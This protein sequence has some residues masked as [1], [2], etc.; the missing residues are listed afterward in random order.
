[1]YGIPDLDGRGPH[2]SY[3]EDRC[4]PTGE[5]NWT[6]SGH[7]RK[8]GSSRHQLYDVR[9]SL[10]NSP[11][12]RRSP[13]SF[14]LSPHA[15]A[16]LHV[17]N[18]FNDDSKLWEIWNLCDP[19][20]LVSDLCFCSC[21]SALCPA[22]AVLRT[23]IC[24]LFGICTVQASLYLIRFLKD[25]LV[26][27]IL[28]STDTI[29]EVNIIHFMHTRLHRLCCYGTPTLPKLVFNRRL[30]S[31]SFQGTS[32]ITIVSWVWLGI[33]LYWNWRRGPLSFSRRGLM[34][35][36]LYN[37]VCVR[38]NEPPSKLLYV[39]SVF[40]KDLTLTY[41]HYE[42]GINYGNVWGHEAPSCWCLTTGA[43]PGGLDLYI[44]SS[45]D[46]LYSTNLSASVSSRDLRPLLK[47][48]LFCSV[49]KLAP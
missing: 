23:R 1:M 36:T 27:R 15:H 18:D 10:A 49:P 14:V 32:G 24:S 37:I 29:L 6:Q 3:H 12:I 33:I 5:Q 28:V 17:I 42:G 20:E 39:L 30:I 11:Y 34:S 16:D 8:D 44:W 43:H 31:C 48:T 4:T 40:F 9:L 13:A 25:P 41:L 2:L 46:I 7:C 21:S 45:S 38:R 47:F 19:N 26:T 35:C 22:P